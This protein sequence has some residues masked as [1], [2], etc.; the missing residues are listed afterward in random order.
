MTGNS[1]QHHPAAVRGNQRV[2]LTDGEVHFLWWFIRGSM[3]NPD[4][5][6]QLRQAWGMCSR[7]AAGLLAVEAAF[8]QGRMQASALL[9]LDLIERAVGAITSRGPFAEVRAARRLD[10]HGPCLMCELRVAGAAS[11]GAPADLLTL[12][13]DS[14]QLTWSANE[15]RRYW[16]PL[17]CRDCR[18]GA[19][20]PRCRVHLVAHAQSV[21][22]DELAPERAALGH[23]YRHLVR[24][25]R[26]FRMEHPGV[27]TPEDR[28]AL[29]EAVGWCSGWSGLFG[30][31]EGPA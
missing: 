18:V 8:R 4:T 29:V 25:A 3:M 22:P 28:A 15:S 21:R 27:D 5:R 16:E 13:R 23:I 10:T 1:T 14:I 20:G 31:F 19:A 6:R 11:G 17:V 9:Y 30:M 24:Y 12:G 2:H 7:H 26:S